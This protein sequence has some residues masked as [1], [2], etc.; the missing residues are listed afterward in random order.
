MDKIVIKEMDFRFAKQ[1]ALALNSRKDKRIRG[2]H[3]VTAL[4]KCALYNAAWHSCEE[5]Q[6]DKNKAVLSFT[7]LPC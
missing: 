7:A 4:I 1:Y 2:N 5:W 3:K 6:R